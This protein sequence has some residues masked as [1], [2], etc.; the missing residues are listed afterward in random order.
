MS[1]PDLR[2]LLIDDDDAP[3][4]TIE[5]A[6]FHFRHLAAVAALLE[7][8][9]KLYRE[10]LARRR[11]EG[12]SE[13]LRIEARDAAEAAATVLQSLGRRQYLAVVAQES[14]FNPSSALACLE[15]LFF[16]FCILSGPDDGL[17]AVALQ[18]DEAETWMEILN[19]G[20]WLE[21]IGARGLQ[22]W[23]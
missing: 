12:T 6:R 15:Q 2:A 22:E 8:H 11:D 19:I 21:E 23:D 16:S 18:E 1:Q 9:P 10:L 3:P 4:E 13:H 5:E 7:H 17:E 20:S 14:P